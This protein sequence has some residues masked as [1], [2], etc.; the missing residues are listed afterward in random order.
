MF[1]DFGRDFETAVPEP[2][3]GAPS[4]TI[5]DRFSELSIALSV[6]PAAGPSAVGVSLGFQSS[7][8]VP[9]NG[10]FSVA[11]FAGDGFEVKFG[12]GDAGL[13][14]QSSDADLSAGKT[15]SLGRHLM[16]GLNE[17]GEAFD[18]GSFADTTLALGEGVSIG[19]FFAS[20]KRSPPSNPK[21]AWPRR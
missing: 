15:P 4:R 1:D 14:F 3:V 10:G 17:A 2:T 8:D 11:S 6:A 19:A 9:S 16:L 18:Q 7:G 12:Q 5:E 20:T 13:Y 21:A